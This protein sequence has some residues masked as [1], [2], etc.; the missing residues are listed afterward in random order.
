MEDG[1]AQPLGA[2]STGW[3]A[4]RQKEGAA[5]KVPQS[6]AASAFKRVS[7]KMLRI[8]GFFGKTWEK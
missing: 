1:D 5:R 3:E 7:R 8:L 4:G 2:E 6:M